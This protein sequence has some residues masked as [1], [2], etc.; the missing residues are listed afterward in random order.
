MTTELRPA[1]QRPYHFTFPHSAPSA[2]A[3]QT[4]FYPCNS[5][6]M[7]FNLAARQAYDN[8]GAAGDT[9]RVIDL[10]P[11]KETGPIRSALIVTDTDCLAYIDSTD[12]P[13]YLPG[14][15]PVEVSLRGIDLFVIR[16]SFANYDI[17]VVT[18]VSVTF[19]VMVTFSNQERPP[20]YVGSYPL[21]YQRT[22][23][24]GVARTMTK[25]TAKGTA[26][27][28]KALNISNV[29]DDSPIFGGAQWGVAAGDEFTDWTEA[30]NTSHL[31]RKEISIA[32]TDNPLVVRIQG[33]KAKGADVT[34]VVEDDP[35]T[36]PG[37][38]I[39]A[40][41]RRTF[42][43][44]RIY[45]QMRIMVRLPI[46]NALNDTADVELE[47]GAHFLAAGDSPGHGRE[48]SIEALRPASGN[49]SGAETTEPVYVGWAS[50]VTVHIDLTNFTIPDADETVTFYVQTTFN[51]T[52]WVD[53][54]SFRH[55]A[56]T[57]QERYL[58]FIA[59]AYAL[60]DPPITPGDGALTADTKVDLGFGRQIRIKV[61]HSD[62]SGADSVYAYNAE[63]FCQA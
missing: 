60:V 16:E 12:F 43:T 37:V 47:V 24:P 23:P 36:G 44:D 21:H 13:L 19:G 11:V 3:P 20:L 42:V 28:W 52:D 48:N 49:I 4:N 34:R 10:P 50:K 25:A 59:S 6:G 51:G 2:D 41:S 29:F 8:R 18:P 35:C 61:A 33:V 39:A 46:T 7:T 58:E 30:F 63:A 53:L 26:D 40:G 17:G 14:G 5:R 45:G 27:T 62:P 31:G 55:N 9:P 57:A 54:E 38:I 1:E 56:A 22:L 32:A 15:V